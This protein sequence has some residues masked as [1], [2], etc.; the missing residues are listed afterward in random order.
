MSTLSTMLTKAAPI[1]LTNRK[2][3]EGIRNAGAA[4]ATAA[5]PLLIEVAPI[6]IVASIPVIVIASAVAMEDD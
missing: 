6:L 3:R 4:V 1:L 2:V 5:A